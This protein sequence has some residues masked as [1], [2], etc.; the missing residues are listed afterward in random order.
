[1]YSPEYIQLEIFS[2]QPGT[3][4][5]RYASRYLI[6]DRAISPSVAFSFQG[7]AGPQEYEWTAADGS[8]GVVA[9][10]PMTHGSMQV[11]WR[12]THFGSQIGLGSGTAVL[13]RKAQE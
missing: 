2:G 12:I 9:L 3:I 1:L 13:I 11:N 5:G 10:N 8:R 6:P 7:P 4:H